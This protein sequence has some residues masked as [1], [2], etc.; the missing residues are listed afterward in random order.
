MA[1]AT[2][3]VFGTAGCHDGLKALYGTRKVRILETDV[4]HGRQVCL[5]EGQRVPATWVP[6]NKLR[7]GEE[8][9]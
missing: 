1:T 9:W 7:I 8:C 5:I 3:Q 6:A 2:K 4:R